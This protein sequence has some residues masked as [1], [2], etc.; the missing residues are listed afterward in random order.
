LP[1]SRGLREHRLGLG[2]AEQRLK[3]FRRVSRTTRRV[4]EQDQGARGDRRQTMQRGHRAG[5]CDQQNDRRLSR[6]A[7]DEHLAADTVPRG[8]QAVLRQASI[9]L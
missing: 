4:V 1:S 5:G 8:R 7:P 3:P 2:E 9:Q 6:W